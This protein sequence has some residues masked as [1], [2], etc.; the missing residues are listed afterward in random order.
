M[1]Y[2]WAV[3]VALV[4]ACSEPN[5]A[6]TCA[7]GGCSDPRFSY[8]DHEG[9]FG[10]PDSCIAV[11][12]TPGA[13]S[14]CHSDAEYTCGLDGHSYEST[15]CDLGCEPAT[16]C[17]HVCEPNATIS[18]AANEAVVCNDSGTAMVTEPCSL[19][20]RAA[21]DRCAA[22]E[23]T[24]G[25]GPSLRDAASQ[26]AVTLAAGTTIDADSGTILDAHSMPI[27]LSS[28]V[29]TQSG[30]LPIRVFKAASFELSDVRI[31][32][33]YPV[34]FVSAGAIT[35][36]GLV[37]VK[38]RAGV[39]GA[40]AQSSTAACAA[41]GGQEYSGGCGPSSVGTGGGGNATPGGIGGGTL[42]SSGLAGAP[43]GTLNGYTPLLGGCAGG[44]VLDLVGG[45][46]ALG[47][48]GGG[49]IQLVSNTGI[50]LQ[51]TG[52]IDAGGGGGGSSAGGG[53][54]GMIVFE[55]PTLTIENPAGFSANGGAGGGCSTF[56]A[57]ASPGTTAA[58]GPNCADFFGGAGGTGY[59]S[60]GDACYLHTGGTCSAHGDC[61]P[62]YG[63]GGGS[64]GRVR[65]ATGSG[66]YHN[67][68]GVI[69]AATTVT[70]LELE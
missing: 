19:G 28:E 43:G 64:V 17:K 56:G 8:C 10:D 68:N 6:A 38:A 25:L 51:G 42:G 23:P 13:F 63:G 37:A 24:N 22:F 44:S 52:Y 65:I 21:G 33:T 61:T 20:C 9:A 60:A 58:L 18:C 70:V 5:P 31:S 66:G 7:A 4:A 67:N 41:I 12:C 49:A 59:A 57:D 69:S 34:A 16:G 2:G 48:G 26:P 47:G 39:A 53:S 14:G 15:H 1:S 62:H 29:V 36:T 11:D 35:V 46:Y 30:S 27:T 50:R 40:G 45:S 55:A 3:G 32:G 54:G